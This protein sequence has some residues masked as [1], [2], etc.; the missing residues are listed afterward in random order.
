MA[1]SS[2]RGFFGVVRAF[3]SCVCAVCRGNGGVGRGSY[4][5]GSNTS[6][7]VHFLAT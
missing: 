6:R 2:V 4:L 3:V 7:L 5:S 1:A